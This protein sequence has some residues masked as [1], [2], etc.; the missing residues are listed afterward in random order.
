MQLMA[1][2]NLTRKLNDIW[3]V[4]KRS[5][6]VN[7]D[8]SRMRKR[9]SWT[10][11]IYS[12]CS[13]LCY[14][15]LSRSTWLVVLHP[16]FTISFS[17]FSQSSIFLDLISVTQIKHVINIEREPGWVRVKEKKTNLMLQN[18]FVATSDGKR[19]RTRCCWFLYTCHGL[20]D[21]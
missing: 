20:K 16:S 15:P 21:I 8:D 1:N 2:K 5:I 12:L 19:L 11:S 9:N 18:I 13:W 14:V 10:S 17:S 6:F 3:I 7:K 4:M